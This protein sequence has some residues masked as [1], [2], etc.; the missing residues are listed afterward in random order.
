[1]RIEEDKKE[2]YIGKLEDH[3]VDTRE[4]FKHALKIDHDSLES[5]FRKYEDKKIKVTI[6]EL[7]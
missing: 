7:D 2:V 3:L 1:M 6:E 5:I 4:V